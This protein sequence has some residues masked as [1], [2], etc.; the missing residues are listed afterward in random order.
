[1]SKESQDKSQGD[2]KFISLTVVTTGEDLEDEKFNVMQPIKVVFQKALVLVGGS[3]NPD[4]FT[5]E[6]N[7]NPLEVDKKISDYVTEFGW[8]DGAVLELLPKPVAV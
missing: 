2:E 5:L 1:M 4:Q 7:D 6:F 3:S 8:E